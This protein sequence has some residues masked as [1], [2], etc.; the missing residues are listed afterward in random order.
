MMF[1]ANTNERICE[2]MVWRKWVYILTIFLGA[3]V[4]FDESDSYMFGE[5]DDMNGLDVWR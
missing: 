1:E 4:L 5:V 3:K 2:G